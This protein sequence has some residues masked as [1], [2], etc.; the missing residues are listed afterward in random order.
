MIPAALRFGPVERGPMTDRYEDVLQ[1]PSSRMMC[2]RV[3]CCDHRDAEGF[4]KVA[5]DRAPA[6]VAAFV[7]PLQLDEE[8]IA[9]KGACEARRCVGIPESEPVSR[10]AGEAHEPVV[11]LLEERLL[12]SRFAGRLRFTSGRSS[13]FVRCREEAAEICVTARVLDEQRHVRPVGERY[14]RSC[15]R[16]HAE[17]FRRMRELERAV[18][19][20]VIGQRERFVAELR[21]AFLRLRCGVSGSIVIL[22][23]DGRNRLASGRRRV[24]RG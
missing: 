3:P 24:P 19:P 8:A 5:Q 1:R 17:V 21:R 7:G 20:V 13:V 9:S 14:L 2:M 15:D 22:A 11:Q 16:T 12:E 18:E 10:A 23:P 4:R 6:P